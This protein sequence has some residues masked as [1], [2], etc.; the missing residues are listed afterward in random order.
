[1]YICIYSMIICIYTYIYT[2]IIHEYILYYIICIYIYVYICIYSMIIC[3]HTYIYIYMCVCVCVL[4]CGHMGLIE[5]VLSFVPM[6]FFLRSAIL[7][8][9]AR[10]QRRETPLHEECNFGNFALKIVVQE[11][12]YG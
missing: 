12:I 11:R 5:L 3:I 2:Y 10:W 6:F 9:Q 7:Y 4:L 8:T 1:M